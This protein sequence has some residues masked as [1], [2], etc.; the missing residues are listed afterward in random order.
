[1]SDREQFSP[2]SGSF[3]Y[4]L[5]DAIRVPDNSPIV[6]QEFTYSL[7]DAM[8]NEEP[9]NHHVKIDQNQSESK[10]RT[11]TKSTSSMFGRLNINTRNI[12]SDSISLQSPLSP[13]PDSIWALNRDVSEKDENNHKRTATLPSG[14]WEGSKPSSFKSNNDQSHLDPNVYERRFSLAPNIYSQYNE[15]YTLN[16]YFNFKL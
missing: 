5:A 6:K 8:K 16:G 2:I 11:R 10:L 15:G 4:S 13:N 1:M 3:S 12:N 14:L 9:V 7:V